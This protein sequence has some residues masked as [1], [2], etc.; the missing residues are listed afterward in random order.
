LV[1]HWALDV[2]LRYRLWIYSGAMVFGC[3]VDLWAL[4]I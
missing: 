1:E 4:D 2:C 3:L